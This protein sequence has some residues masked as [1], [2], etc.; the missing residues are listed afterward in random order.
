VAVPSPRPFIGRPEIWRTLRARRETVVAGRGAVSILEGDAG[1]GKSVLLTSF[2]E[3]CEHSGDQ[4]LRARAPRR[5]NPPPFQLIREVLGTDPVPTPPDTDDDGGPKGSENRLAEML[6]SLGDANEPIQVRSFAPLAEQFFALA[7]H[8]PTIVALENVSYADPLSLAFLAY[9]APLLGSHR[10]WLILASLPVGIA[11]ESIRRLY[12]ALPRTDSVD[13]WLLRPLNPSE[14]PEFVRWVDPAKVPRPEELT[15]WFTQTGG[16]PLFLEQILRASHRSTPSVWEEARDSGLPLPEY[17]HGR[18]NELPEE[19]RRVLRLASVIGRE[20]S[21]PLLFAAAGMEEE[22]LAELVERL[23][24]RG[25]LCE[26]AHDLLEFP[27]DDLRD[28]IYA[29]VTETSQQLLHGRVADA[30]EAT[31]RTD[32]DTIF[33]LA[34]HTFLAHRDAE[35]VQY[36]RRAA[37]FATR[38]ASPE[39]SRGH[40]ERALEALRRGR[41]EDRVGELELVLE[42]SLTLDRS[43]ELARAEQLLREAL[44]Q[45]PPPALPAGVAGELLPIYLARILTDEGRWDDA[46]RLTDDLLDHFEL[47]Q[48]ATARLALYRLRGE[49]EYYRGEYTEAIRYQEHALEI[50]RTS[51]DLR[52]VALVTVRRAN[53][54]AMIPE[55]V[56]EAIPAYR[57]AAEELTRLGDRAEAAY[58]LLFLGVTLSQ[59]GQVAEGLEELESAAK[60][61]E[62]ASDLRQLGW[63]LFNIADLRR[64]MND[65]DQ[66]RKHNARAREILLRVGDQF[67]LAQ[68]HIIAGKIEIAAEEFGAAEGELLEAFRIVREL[69]TEPDELEVLLRLAEVALGR[70]EVGLA[71]QRARELEHRQIARLRPDLLA[72]VRRVLARVESEEGRSSGAVPA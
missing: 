68:T 44:R 63:A 19:E 27:R 61:S 64:E 28:L 6:R 71:R 12:E 2:L 24:E 1:V 72:D 17:V 3:E 39:I 22:R 41:P 35:A 47:I 7:Q 31:G 50:A 26:S 16:N 13:R 59:S 69:R 34:H 48:S 54:L 43:G 58:A 15:R 8:A 42:L 23:V 66:A 37:E 46:R 5:P 38:V 4:V 49:I 57:E 55:T 67:G 20:F 21:F 14:L 62:A 36:N 9:L 25:L 45:G 52:E 70:G 32:S 29:G 65:L 40:L 30:L 51:G 53:A 18:V 11:P 60:L 56:S 10:L 33:A